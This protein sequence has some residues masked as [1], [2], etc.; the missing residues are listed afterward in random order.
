MKEL[1]AIIAILSVMILSIPFIA[2]IGAHNVQSDKPQYS[3]SRAATAHL[4]SKTAVSKRKDAADA[5]AAALPAST[6]C[7]RVLD[8][9][10]GRIETIGAFDYVCGVV[11]AE[12][13]AEYRPEALKAQAV[14]AFTYALYRRKF[15][16]AH[17]GAASAGSGADVS[18]DPAVCDNFF[19]EADAKRAWGADFTRDWAKIESAV[20]AVQNK[21]ILY[22]GHPIK[23]F[24]FDMSAGTT[25]SSRDVWGE[26]LPYLQEVPSPGDTLA[27]GFETKVAFTAAALRKKVAAAYPDA[28]FAADPA[29]WIAGVK[30]SA[31]GGIL[32]ATVCGK[33]LT[34]EQIRTLFGLHSAN[35][36]ISV[37]NNIFTFDVKGYGHGVGMSQ[38]G[39][40]YMAVQGKNYQ[41]IITWYYRGA[42][43]ADCDWASI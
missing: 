7:F 35:A 34:G 10:T 21:V 2:C 14:A 6:G 13:P 11:A 37:Q 3:M 12:E 20:R 41:Q 5:P 29:K 15:N 23:A 30:R 1:F 9:D 16:L 25:E 39:S 17:P 22:D 43:I 18:T 36:K 38:V 27:H 40:E 26:D 19:S 4:G 28:Q 32:T 31:A 42:Q 24:F 33:T 8:T